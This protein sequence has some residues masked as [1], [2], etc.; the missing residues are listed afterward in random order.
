MTQ[1]SEEDEELRLLL[2]QRTHYIEQMHSILLGSGGFLSPTVSDESDSSDEESDPSKVNVKLEPSEH[3]NSEN[4]IIDT[5]DDTQL[6]VNIEHSL[7][8][9]EETMDERMD[10]EEVN[11]SV[12]DEEPSKPVSKEETVTENIEKTVDDENKTDKSVEDDQSM[13]IS[14]QEDQIEPKIS[15][16]HEGKTNEEEINSTI[17]SSTRQRR[18]RIRKSPSENELTTKIEQKKL[19]KIKQE[20]AESDHELD[21]AEDTIDDSR[22]LRPR[23]LNDSRNYFEPYD[24]SSSDDSDFSFPSD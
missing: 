18:V 23:K 17:T 22:E 20:P 9:K 6:E 14:H 11:D 21:T 2:E 5:K 15:D 12:E 4:Q 3:N 10:C 24:G 1:M 13:I 19:I 7:K 16:D 8:I